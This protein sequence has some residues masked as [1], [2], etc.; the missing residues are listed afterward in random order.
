MSDLVSQNINMIFKLPKGEGSNISHL[1]N[2]HVLLSVTTFITT[3]FVSVYP[4]TKFATF[5]ANSDWLIP[6]SLRNRFPRSGTVVAHPVTAL[7][8]VMK[9][10]CFVV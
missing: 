10:D 1:K 3:S 9:T 5:V 4:I 8:A 6:P 2:Y 7:P